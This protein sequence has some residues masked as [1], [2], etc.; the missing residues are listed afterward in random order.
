LRV[1]CPLC[2]ARLGVVVFPG[3]A[4]RAGLCG[5]P[6]GSVRHNLREAGPLATRRPMAPTQESM[7]QIAERH[8][9]HPADVTVCAG[10]L[11]GSTLYIGKI[12]PVGVALTCLRRVMWLRCAG[13]GH[14]RL[15][16]RCQGRADS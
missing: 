9:L 15:L 1:L 5:V 16:W 2:A 13:R 12:A 11:W 14:V 6:V 3:V 4:S 10:V 7:S 8:E